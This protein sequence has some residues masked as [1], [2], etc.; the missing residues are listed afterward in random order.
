MLLP[1]VK[2]LAVDTTTDLGGVAVGSDGVLEGAVLVRS[3]RRYSETLVPMLDFVLGHLQGSLDEIG[4]LAVATGPGSFTGVRVGLAVVK[5]IGQSRKIPGLGLSTLE[6]LAGCFSEY[7]RPVAPMLDAKRGQIYGAVYA[8]VDGRTR[9]CVEEQ[10]LSP[11]SW[12]E[13]LPPDISP[14]FVGAG[15]AAHRDLITSSRPGARVI[16]RQPPLFEALIRLADER[17]AEAVAVEELR[18]NYIR[19]SDAEL[20]KNGA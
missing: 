10:V 12:L 11:E 16:A 4:L 18:A 2:I 3:P 1:A 20:G 7:S 8:S 14:L 5:A 19:P 13:S 15:A 9:V 17:A 6:A